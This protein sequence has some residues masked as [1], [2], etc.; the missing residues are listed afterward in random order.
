MRALC[1]VAL[2][3]HAITASA[4]PDAGPPSKTLERAIKLYDK[5]DFYSSSV[6]LQKVLDGESGDAAANKQRADFFMGKSLFQLKYTAASLAMFDRIVQ[7]TEHRYHQATIKWLIAIA[8]AT[9]SFATRG[10]LHAYESD[11]ALDPMFDDKTRDAFN[12]FY[13]RASADRESPTTEASLRKVTG[14]YRSRAALELAKLAFRA[15]RIDDAIAAIEIA[16]A[17]PALTDT[18]ARVLA[19]WS[20]LLGYPDHAVAALRR[21]AGTNALAALEFSRVSVTS[22]FPDLPG[23]SAETFDAVAIATTCSGPAS[24]DDGVT[25]L[26]TTSADL[27]RLVDKLLESDDHAELHDAVEK[28]LPRSGVLRLA[29]SDDSIQES[30]GWDAE[31]VR[32]LDLLQHADKAWQTTQ[33]A[34]EILQELTIQLAIGQSD[35]GKRYRDR[36]ETIRREL[37]ILARSFDGHASLALGPAIQPGRGILTTK[38]LC[39]SQL[40][41]PAEVA[42]PAVVVTPQPPRANGCAGCTTGSQDASA[43]LLLAVLGG[44]RRRKK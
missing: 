34:A 40:G 35:T 42:G 11:A 2:I 30:R 32:E 26:R 13:G 10:S 38:A 39:S 7:N 19:T 31:L 36:L 1:A 3:T 16:A 24:V 23:V 14:G 8:E 6:E 21:L 43:L 37:S 4:Q 27:R 29:L 20:R 18:A 9:P 25:G 41:M 17:D 22:R 33:I 12:Y 15:Q 44:L 5:Q 28:V